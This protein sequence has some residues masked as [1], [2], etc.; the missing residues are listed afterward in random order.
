MGPLEISRPLGHWHVVVRECDEEEVYSI[1]RTAVKERYIILEEAAP[2]PAGND[3]L[4][5]AEDVEPGADSSSSDPD[6]EMLVVEAVCCSVCRKWLRGQNLRSQ[7]EDHKR[8]REH[9]MR[10]AG[11]RAVYDELDWSRI[12]GTVQLHPNLRKRRRVGEN[13]GQLAIIQLKEYLKATLP[14]VILTGVYAASF[15]RRTL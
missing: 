6:G 11:M 13:P 9:L 4:P 3:G 2:L 7:Y 14:Y 15:K 12:F 10:V 8:N 1:V 5:R